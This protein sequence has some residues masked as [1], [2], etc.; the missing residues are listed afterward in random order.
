MRRG[1]AVVVAVLGL[2]TA[3]TRSTAPPVAA[4]LPKVPKT[5]TAPGPCANA[6]FP[7]APGAAWYYRI[8]A[9]PLHDTYADTVTTVGDDYFVVTSNDTLIARSARWTCRPEGLASLDAGGGVGASVSTT[10]FGQTV[11]TRHGRGLSL[12]AEPKPGDRWRQSFEVSSHGLAPFTGTVRVRY[13]ALRFDRI[14]TPAGHYRALLV[15]SYGRYDLTARRQPH[16]VVYTVV[17]GQWW[18]RGVGLVRQDAE[19]H[20][21]DGTYRAVADLTKFEKGEHGLG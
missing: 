1:I 6:Y 5:P 18:V 11:A 10:L 17:M 21:A 7:S 9:G 13:Q 20:T 19:T 3:C 16:H 15:H 12:P 14:A 8:S 2:A 4:P